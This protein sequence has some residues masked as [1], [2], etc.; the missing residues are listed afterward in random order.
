MR[1]CTLLVVVFLLVSGAVYALDPPVG[2]GTEEPATALHIA[3]DNANRG[4]LAGQLYITREDDQR[5]GLSVGVTLDPEGDVDEDVYSWLQS[6]HY[7]A[8]VTPYL[9]L[10]LNGDGGNVAVGRPAN[11]RPPSKLSV[12]GGDVE[13]NPSQYGDVGLVL[14]SPNGSCARIGLADDY[15][16]TVTPISCP[17]L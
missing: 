17:S 4:N 12:Y 7:K 1:R 5:V 3:Q 10:M 6:G 8:G 2:I 13:I 9:P 15:S 14:H 11:N 16:L